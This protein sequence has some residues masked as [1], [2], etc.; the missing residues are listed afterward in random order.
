VLLRL[1]AAAAVA[2]PSCSLPQQHELSAAQALVLAAHAAMLECGFVHNQP[3]TGSAQQQEQEQQEQ[4]ET[5]LQGQQGVFSAA[6]QLPGAACSAPPDHPG[7]RGGSDPQSSTVVSV[8]LRGIDMGRHLVLTGSLVTTAA[9]GAAGAGSRPACK[10]VAT[11]NLAKERAQPGTPAAAAADPAAAM[12]CAY[13]DL[14]ALWVA[15]KD[16][17]GLPLLVAACAAAGLPSPTGLNS[18]MYELQELILA[19]LQVGAACLM[20]GRAG[21]RP[22][23][24][25]LLLLKPLS[26]LASPAQAR[27]LA[28]LCCSC[29]PLRHRASTDP[30]WQPLFERE[31]PTGPTPAAP[32]PAANQQQQQ[33]QQQ[34]QAVGSSEL[35]RQ[36]DVML[37]HGQKLAWR[38]S[39]SNLRREAGRRGWK[40]AFGAAWSQRARV[41]AD[42]E[43]I[44]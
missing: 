13:Q 22:G 12:L 32:A 34:Q 19:G 29:S 26:V 43:R 31:F 40:W 41:L 14:P 37:S 33:Q 10:L 21:T 39:L 27:D 42:A 1:L 30:L 25:H 2:A 5:L 4:L 7:A 17:L 18:L 23:V 24:L 36:L 44:R 8:E 16:Q 38:Q 20:G 11:L 3:P 9:A 6:Y 28:A 35:Q 15:L